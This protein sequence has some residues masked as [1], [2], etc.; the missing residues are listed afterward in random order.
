MREENL[1]G[2]LNRDGY[3]AALKD[4]ATRLSGDDAT[5]L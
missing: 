2:E 1:N 3:V 5:Y 4:F